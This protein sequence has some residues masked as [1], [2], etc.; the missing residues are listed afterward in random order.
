MQVEIFATPAQLLNAIIAELAHRI[1]TATKSGKEFHLALTG[2][3]IG[4]DITTAIGQPEFLAQINAKFLHLWWSDER[5]VALDS[6][7]RNDGAITPALIAAGVRIHRGP[8]QANNAVLQSSAELHNATTTRFCAANT[9]MDLTLLSIGP[10]GHIAS[11]FPGHALLDATA[12]IAVITDSPKPPAE[13]VTW[14][15]PTIN[16]SESV[17]LIASGKAKSAVVAKLLAGASSH[18]IPAAG[19]H[20]KNETRLL[21]DQEAAGPE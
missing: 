2:G 21:L 1:S 12:G 5:L 4:S 9:L 15:F 8:T 16:A 7:L 3:S 19:V 11:L 18:E 13:R 10:D 6:E 17:W 20:G 14:T